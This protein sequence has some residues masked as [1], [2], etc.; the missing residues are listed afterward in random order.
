M[1]FYHLNST[2]LATGSMV[3]PGNWG[4]I[5]RLYGISHNRFA[6]EAVVDDIRAREFPQAPSRLDCAYFFDDLGEARFYGN[7]DQSRAMMLL[8]EVEMVEPEARIL[9]TDWRGT[10]PDGKMSLDWV[11]RYWAGTMLPPHDS[12]Y[13]CREL[14]ADTALRIVGQLPR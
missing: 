1:T 10:A 7:S 9:R 3:L 11:R 8:Y 5:I 2:P 13:H 6:W 4:R 14:L 12:G